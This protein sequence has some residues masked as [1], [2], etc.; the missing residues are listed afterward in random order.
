MSSLPLGVHVGDYVQVTTTARPEYN[1]QLW[2]VHDEQTL[3]GRVTLWRIDDPNEQEQGHQLIDVRTD[4]VTPV[5]LVPA[6]VSDSMP[7]DADVAMW[8][9]FLGADGAHNGGEVPFLGQ[10]RFYFPRLNQWI[11]LPGHHH[12][13]HFV[14]VREAIDPQL[15]TNVMAL[16]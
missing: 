3:D 14:M 8:M 13:P 9:R 11:P 10:R 7:V 1:N 12:P 2:L 4:A 6:H 5:A 15:V 16:H